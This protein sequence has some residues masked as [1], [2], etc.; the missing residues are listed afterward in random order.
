MFLLNIHNTFI[1]SFHYPVITTLQSFENVSGNVV[2][3][4]PSGTGGN[5][6]AESARPI[7]INIEGKDE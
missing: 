2:L 1:Y 3:I 6:L 4:S 5:G 7:T